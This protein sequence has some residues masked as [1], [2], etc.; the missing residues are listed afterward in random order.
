MSMISPRASDSAG[1]PSFRPSGIPEVPGIVT[2]GDVI[3]T[4]EYIASLQDDSGAISWP[5]GHAD[6]WNHV[7][8]VMALSAC[9]L[10]AAA[11]R[12]YRW[13]RSQQRADGSWP[14]RYGRL[15]PLRG[16]NPAGQSSSCPGWVS[17]VLAINHGSPPPKAVSWPWHWPWPGNQTVPG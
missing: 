14:G 3:A 13:L 11:R 6:P 4:G 10:T 2:A 12:G 17:G 7:E 15:W 1:Y 16:W 8:C 9:G 5:D